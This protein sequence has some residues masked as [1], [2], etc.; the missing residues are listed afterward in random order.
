MMRFIDDEKLR[1]GLAYAA[2]LMHKLLEQKAVR[3]I[4]RRTW[5][6]RETG[7]SSNATS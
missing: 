4:W 5:E 6:G 3:S 1:L 7:V 2:L